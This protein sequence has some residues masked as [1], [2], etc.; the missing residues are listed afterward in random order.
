MLLNFT[1]M[2]WIALKWNG[3]K[4]ELEER[5]VV[6]SLHA[7]FWLNEKLISMVD[8][9]WC[10]ENWTAFTLWATNCNSLMDMTHRLNVTITFY[11]SAHTTGDRFN[12]FFFC[13]FFQ[14]CML[15]IENGEVFCWNKGKHEWNWFRKRSS[16]L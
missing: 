8:L 9:H 10:V 3:I 1:W 5:M 4:I 7:D 6:S 15:R 2:E 14:P 12:L 11:S 13:Y 16:T